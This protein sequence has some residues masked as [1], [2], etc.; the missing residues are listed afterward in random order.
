LSQSRSTEFQPPLRPPKQQRSRDTLARIVNAAE[1]LLE[2]RRFED[3]SVADIAA[4]AHSSV[5]AFYAR[6]VDKDGLLD[7]LDELHA[8]TLVQR[9]SEYSEDPRWEA[10]SA[11]VFVADVIGFLVGYFKEHRGVLR[12]LAIRARLGDERFAERTRQ[13]NSRVPELIRLVLSRRGEIAHA[14]PDLAAFLGFVMMLSTLRA[15]VLFPETHPTHLPISDT[16]LTDELVSM[17]LAYLG[18]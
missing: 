9:V 17:Y 13:V 12:A 1:R 3:V 11:R 15:R 16:L 4:R 7:Y 18:I 5:G 6:F 2:E 14:S 8:E 10:V